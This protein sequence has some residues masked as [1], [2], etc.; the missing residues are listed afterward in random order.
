[1]SVTYNEAYDQITGRLVEQWALMTPAIVG[2]VPELR[3]QD[4]EEAAIPSG[5]FARFVMDPVS[6]PQS[7]LRNG[8]H[9]QRYEANGIIIVQLL[10]K[11]KGDPEA[12]KKMRLLATGTQDIFRDPAFPGC[13]IFRNVRPNRLEP[14]PSYLRTNVIVEYQFDY[15]G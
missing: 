11:R 9:G 8:E 2:M 3:F 15:I 5:T 1:M 13:Y 7:A 6:E 14:E 12:G 10:V 4:V